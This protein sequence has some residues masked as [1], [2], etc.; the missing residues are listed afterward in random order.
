MTAPLT[1]QSIHPSGTVVTTVAAASGGDT[2]F[3]DG[4]TVLEVTNANVGASRTVTIHK[5]GTSINTPAGL[6]ALNDL[7]VTV[8]ASSTVRIGPLNPAHFN[9][10]TGMISVT[11]SNSAADLTVAVVNMKDSAI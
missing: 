8:A 1:V 3:N 2:F 9:S 7:V 10:N 6:L 5:A 11:Y 4:A